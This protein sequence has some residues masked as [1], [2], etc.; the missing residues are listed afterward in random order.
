MFCIHGL[1]AGVL[2]LMA[3]VAWAQV[4]TIPYVQVCHQKNIQHRIRLCNEVVVRGN[5]AN[6]AN[7]T[8]H[9]VK[10][11]IGRFFMK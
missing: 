5:A 9:N 3:I 11:N 7:F 1:K 4:Q 6:A 8:D 2:L 10:Q